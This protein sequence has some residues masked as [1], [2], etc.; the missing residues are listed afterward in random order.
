MANISIWNCL[1]NAESDKA[2]TSVIQH[3]H[4]LVLV[5]VPLGVAAPLAVHATVGGF[6]LMCRGEFA[7]AVSEQQTASEQK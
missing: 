4:V 7:W 3:A 6:V 5:V 1:Q 2:R